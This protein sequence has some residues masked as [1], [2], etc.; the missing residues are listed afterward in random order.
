[1]TCAT[2]SVLADLDT[3]IEFVELED[4][5]KNVLDPGTLRKELNGR[6]ETLMN[7]RQKLD[8]IDDTKLV[9]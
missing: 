4:V 7:A 2:C 6:L 8:D 5:N 3:P 9:C 1:M